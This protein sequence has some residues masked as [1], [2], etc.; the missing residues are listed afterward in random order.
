MALI[1]MTPYSIQ[2]YIQ[3][4]VKDLWKCVFNEKRDTY[5]QEN[6]GSECTIKRIVNTFQ[7]KIVYWIV[8][9][10]K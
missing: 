10:F 8:V 9:R 7:K 2:R 3:K 1:K 4:V 6:P 5:S